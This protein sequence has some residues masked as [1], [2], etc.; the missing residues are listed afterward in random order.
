MDGQAFYAIAREHAWARSRRGFAR[1]GMGLLGALGLWL[2]GGGDSAREADAKRRRRRRRKKRNGRPNP[3]N[4][5]PVCPRSR[6]V[7]CPAGRCCP[8]YRP[9]CCAATAYDPYGSCVETGGTCCTAEEGGGSCPPWLPQCCEPTPRNA[10]GLCVA[11]DDKCCTADEGGGY[12]EPPFTQCCRPTEKHPL[13]T[14][15]GDT[16]TCCADDT[17]CAT[18]A[19]NTVCGPAGCC[20][21]PAAPIQAESAGGNR[22]RQGTPRTVEAAD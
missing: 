4:P 21:P 19:T 10:R 8:N 20:V 9:Q 17:D 22:R 5:T 11:S 18:E 1:G 2:L 3:V 16:D 12:C 6:P 15:C 7:A 13:G 14:C